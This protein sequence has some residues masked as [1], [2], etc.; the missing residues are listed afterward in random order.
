MSV[1]IKLTNNVDDVLRALDE[2]CEAALEAVGNQAVS[3]A[4]QNITQAGRVDTGALRTSISHV[5][6]TGE[7]T[8]YVGTNQSYAIYHEMGTG[9]YAEGGGR[10][11]PWYYVDSHGDGHW[12]RGIKP[13]HFLKNAAA[14]H[15]KE[16]VE[17][18]KQ[19]LKR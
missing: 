13:I 19:Y 8:V 10:Q 4:K 6:S 1:D 11:T 17:I 16:Y 7:K 5:T 18:I 14:N 2:Q 3:H 12:T 15:A 9:I